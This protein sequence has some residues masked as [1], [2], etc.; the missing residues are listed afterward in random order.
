[1]DISYDYY[2]IFYFVGRYQSISKAAEML[3]SNQ[4]NVTKIINKLENQLGCSLFVRSNRGVVFTAEGE[5]LY[6]RV[7]IAYQQIRQAEIEL[8]DDMGLE[9]GIVNIGISEIAMYGLMPVLREFHND[10]PNVRI[11]LYND[12]TP[13]TMSS[14]KEGIVDFALVTTPYAENNGNKVTEIAEF[15]EILVAGKQYLQ[16]VQEG[17]TTICLESIQKYPHISLSEESGTHE[18][19]NTLFGQHGL[20]FE[21]DIQVATA[22][23]IILL[24]ENGIGIGFVA[25]FMAEQAL[26]EKSLVK[27]SLKEDIP[28]RKICLV[29][30]MSKKLTIV[31]KALISRVLSCDY[32]II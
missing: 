2:R 3:K 7:K 30:D 5:K 16:N 25:E 9:K 12:N 20:A 32:T 19:Y 28:K 31:S 10:Y 22:S 8:Q 14:L 18:F 13:N 6:R 23:Q 29:E 17:S 4:P 1:M 26:R 11:R 21:P 24:I 27:I 15:S